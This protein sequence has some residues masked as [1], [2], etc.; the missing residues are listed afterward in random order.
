MGIAAALLVGY[1]IFGSGD[2]NVT[3]HT[4]GDV[5]VEVV[6]QSNAPVPAIQA[7]KG[8]RSGS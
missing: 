7:T 4:E 3:V 6:E 2:T 1:L 5:I 8:R